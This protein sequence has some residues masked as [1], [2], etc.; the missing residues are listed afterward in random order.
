MTQT[1]A[2]TGRP[3]PFGDAGLEDVQHPRRLG[4]GD[5]QRR[6]EGEDLALG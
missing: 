5:D 6:R 3:T 1:A 2:M 4:L